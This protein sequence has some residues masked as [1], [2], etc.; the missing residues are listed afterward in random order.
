MILFP[1]APIPLSH[2]A[3]CLN[4]F[5]IFL[6][7]PLIV[8]SHFQRYPGHLLHTLLLLLSFSRVTMQQGSLK[9]KF[10]PTNEEEKKFKAST[11]KA[12]ADDYLAGNKSGSPLLLLLQ[13]P[14]FY[15]LLL[16]LLLLLERFSSSSLS[17]SSAMSPLTA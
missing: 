2:S 10:E 8:L 1:K 17:S 9:Y 14:C 16:L 5:F 15:I 4:F 12:F 6:F 7:L 13:S 3:L 11:F